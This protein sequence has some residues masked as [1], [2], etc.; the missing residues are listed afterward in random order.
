M[1]THGERCVLSMLSRGPVHT[2]AWGLLGDSV[3]DSE[4]VLVRQ[5]LVARGMIERVG[6]Q[7][8]ESWRITV[9]GAYALERWRAARTRG[10][11]L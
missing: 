6:I 3:P 5:T 11:Q 2:G 7:G 8:I 1:L 10:E 9:N 4:R